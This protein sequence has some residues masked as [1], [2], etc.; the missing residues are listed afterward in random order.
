MG[1]PMF[2]RFRCFFRV[3]QGFLLGFQGFYLVSR[4]LLVFK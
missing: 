4:V 2:S 3:F 1:V